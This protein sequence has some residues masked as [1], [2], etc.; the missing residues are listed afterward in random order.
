MFSCRTRLFLGLIFG[1]FA[2]GATLGMPD[3]EHVNTLLFLLNCEDNPVRF[4]HQLAKV[5]IEILA[6]TRFSATLW[7]FFQGIDFCIKR[8]QPARRIQRGTFMDL[9]EGFPNSGL[10]L[11]GDDNVILHFNEIPCSVASVDRNSR[12][13]RPSPRFA[14]S[15]PYRVQ[16]PTASIT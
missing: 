10:R 7:N 16:T 13:T 9:G 15:S 6:L 12:I 4:A 11:S 5:L 8:A 1:R 3:I 2:N 14:C